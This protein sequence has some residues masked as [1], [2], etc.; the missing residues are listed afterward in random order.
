MFVNDKTI[1]RVIACLNAGNRI[2]EAR[3]RTN[4]SKSEIDSILK[5]LINPLSK[6]FDG[7][8]Y[9][10]I[11]LREKKY[12]KERQK[13]IH[14]T[15]KYIISG[16]SLEEAAEKTNINKEEKK[17]AFELLNDSNSDFYCPLRYQEIIAFNKEEAKRKQE[18]YEQKEEKGIR[19]LLENYTKKEVCQEVGLSLSRLN[20]AIENLN[21]TNSK[22]YNPDLYLEVKVAMQETAAERKRQGGKIRSANSNVFSEKNQ[23][24]SIKTMLENKNTLLQQSYEIGWLPTKFYNYIK[25]CN[26]EK[27]LKQVTPILEEYS[28]NFLEG[29]KDKKLREYPLNIQLDLVMT[30][31]TFRLSLEGMILLFH[32]TPDD[33]IALF[34]SFDS[35]KESL[36]HLYYETKN[37]PDSHRKKALKEANDYWKTRNKLTSEFN[38]ICKEIKI[39]EGNK[40]LEENYKEKQEEKHKLKE[41]MKQLHTKIDDTIVQSLL[42]KKFQIYTEEER[43]YV[44]I[45]RHKYYLS[46][47]EAESRLFMDK[48]SIRLC[49]KELAE[50]DP[51]YREQLNDMNQFFFKLNSSK[52]T[53]SKSIAFGND[54]YSKPIDLD[55]FSLKV[56]NWSNAETDEENLSSSRG[57]GSR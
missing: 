15:A 12:Q 30:A 19:L 44:A 57:G 47:T 43:N 46:I 49:E 27:L 45:Y 41:T 29:K 35:L 42:N 3:K 24:K 13:L 55:F 10:E 21:N 14:L 37:E 48:A 9:K 7:K 22:I 6:Y 39:L 32:T 25:T 36:Q 26:D 34:N 20:K 31:L 51:I 4:C 28:K 16:S 40:D 33:I 38:R 54:S 18:E 5:E 8:L 1:V 50:K 56:F 11:V 23:Y 53:P 52:I 17:E 2:E